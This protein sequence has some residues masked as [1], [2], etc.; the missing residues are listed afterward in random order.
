MRIMFMSTRQLGEMVL[1]KLVERG[2]NVV[3]VASL[4]VAPGTTNRM[5]EA[6]TRLGIPYVEAKSGRSPEF[7]E[8]YIKLKPDLNIMARFRTIVPESILNYPKLGTIGWH[9]S[10]LPKYAGADSLTWAIIFGETKTANTILWTDKGIDTGPILLQKEVEISPDDTSASLYHDKI[11]PGAVETIVEAID[12]IKNGTAPR[13]PQDL[14]RY[15]YYSFITEKDALINWVQPAKRIYDL[16]RGTNPYPG[17]TTHFQDRPFK[18]LD[19]ELHLGFEGITLEAVTVAA[20]K[21]GGVIDI[22]SQGIRV[23]AP[24]GVILIKA[25]CVDGS[26]IR[27]AHFADQVGVKVG[28][29]FGIR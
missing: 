18:V 23:V 2:E 13:I 28:D 12:L 26:K 1:K 25:V 10:L 17:A 4:A 16:I 3:G 5:K 21:A 11:T 8:H 29:R 27:A 24:D 6:A 9:P 19:S 22:T 20:I 15:S 7:Y 14:S